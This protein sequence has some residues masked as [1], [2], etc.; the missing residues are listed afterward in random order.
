[1]TKKNF[2]HCICALITLACSCLT[3]SA[4]SYY[5]I[6]KDKTY[7]KIEIEEGLNLPLEWSDID[8]ITFSVPQFPIDPVVTDG[9]TVKIEYSESGA[10]VSIPEKYLEM[11]TA[12]SIGGN[13]VINSSASDNEIIYSLSGT[14]ESGSLLFYG[15]YKAT[16]VLNGL[17]LTSTTGAAIDIECG[18]RIAIELAE[19]TDNYLADSADGEQKACLYIK[20]HTEF[21]KGGTLTVAGHTKHAI[22]SKEYVLVKKSIGKI[23]VTEAEGDGIHAGQYFKMNG[24]VVDIQKG[25]K[26]DG[27][28]AE[29]TK[30]ETDEMNGQMI[31]GGGTLNIAL[32][33]DYMK[34]L[35]SDSLMTITDGDITLTTSGKS[36]EKPSEDQPEETVSYKLYVSVPTTT[37]GGGGGPGGGQTNYYWNQDK[38]YLYN[39]DGTLVATITDKVSIK[40]GSTTTNFFC[41]DFGQ[42][43][44][45]EI[46][47]FK[48][49][50]Y[51]SQGGGWGGGGGTTYAIRSNTVKPTLDG[52]G[53][54]FYVISSS[55]TTSGT[56]YTYSITD[57]TSTYKNGTISQAAGDITYAE[58]IKAENYLQQGGTITMAA[59]GTAG[60]GISVDGDLTITGGTNTITCTGAG[61][62][63]GNNDSYA[64]R[65]YKVDGNFYLYGGS[66]TIKMTGTGGKGIKVEG[67]AVVGSKTEDYEPLTLSVTTT[68]AAVGTTSGGMDQGYIGSTKAF[69]VMGT[70]TQNGGDVSVFT[71]KS[72]AEGI[73]SKSTM[74]F[75]GGTI[76]A[77]CYDD[78]INS[79]GKQTFA[80]TF[81]YCYGTGNDAID[82]NYNQRGGITISGG[83]VVAFSTKG[84]PEEGIDID[85]MSNLVIN[86]GYVFCG[87]GK[88]SSVSSLATTSTQSY[89]IYSSSVTL[90]T[91]KY[92]TLV[93]NNGNSLFSVKTPA[94]VSS[95]LTI[96]SAP[97][98]TKST[99]NYVKSSSTAPTSPS[100]QFGDYIY[101]GGTT[102]TLTNSFQFTS[103]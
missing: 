54:V 8:S 64:G 59:S 58:C 97:G 88:Q 50:N 66:H 7:Q 22:S 2:K 36:G 18:K 89:G 35:K 67:N 20:G 57:K 76:Y 80:G 96:V 41:Y 11:V 78:C 79:A 46:F 49:D 1:M 23:I 83:A 72:G 47:Y 6:C 101:I 10:V 40:Y 81:V 93:D 92:F 5:Y 33:S 24:G 14:S 32:S 85:N 65:G 74:D 75:N 99:V 91:N 77:K 103:K 13:V 28:Q 61:V 56:T 102:G 21:S 38:I 68:A 95:K 82:C 25:V 52:T 84:D 43:I 94:N 86:G 19:G 53:S 30:D 63:V 71:S 62:K 31:I 39:N 87:G 27:I 9:D 100:S 48:S 16:F 55:R 44:S 4:Q 26:G 70:Y 17:S 42:P 73:E 45:G 37:G 69:K 51:T 90:S 12:S 15:S 29:T 34:C 60:R 3:V 98:M